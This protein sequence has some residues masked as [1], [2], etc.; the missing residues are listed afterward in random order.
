MTGASA[1]TQEDKIHSLSVIQSKN[2]LQSIQSI[3]M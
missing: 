2:E 1:M 3:A